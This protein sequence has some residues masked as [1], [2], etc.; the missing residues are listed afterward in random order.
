M[1]GAEPDTFLE[2]RLQEGK[3]MTKDG[4]KQLVIPGPVEVRREILEAQT[5]L[6]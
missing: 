4:H 1:A 3:L 6:S 2:S 5:H